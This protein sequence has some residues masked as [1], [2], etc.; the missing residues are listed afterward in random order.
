MKSSACVTSA[1]ARLFTSSI[2]LT[3]EKH[4]PSSFPDVSEV[5][6][7]DER[8]GIGHVRVAIVRLAEDNHVVERSDLQVVQHVTVAGVAHP[9]FRPDVAQAPDARRLVHDPR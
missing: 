3:I 6:E 4:R 8:G 1:S 5:E 2:S 7:R 9:A